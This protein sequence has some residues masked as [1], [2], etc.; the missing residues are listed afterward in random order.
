MQVPK[1]LLIDEPSLGLAPVIVDQ[2]EDIIL[3][4]R[5]SG[6]AVLMIE[7]N[8][9]LIRDIADRVY[10]FDHGQSVFN[11]TVDDIIN[12]SGLSRAYLGM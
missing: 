1:I 12:N 10:V 7:G 8:M 5:Q 9:D 11:G 3:G 6:V 2:L 4:V